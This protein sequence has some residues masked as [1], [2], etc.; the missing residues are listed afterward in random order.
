[1]ASDTSAFSITLKAIN[2]SKQNIVRDGT[3]REKD[4]SPFVVNRMMSHHPDMVLF[5][6]D[7][8]VSGVTPRMTFEFL[9]HTATIKN[10]FAPYVKPK[11][12]EYVD[13][14]MAKLNVSRVKAEEYLQILSDSQIED[15]KIIKANYIEQTT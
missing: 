12:S 1:M 2:T 6:N 3:I 8:N 5:V 11:N 14:L 15:L 7:I 4:I 13:F 10:R 9:M